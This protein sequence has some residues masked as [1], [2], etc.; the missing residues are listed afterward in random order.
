MENEERLRLLA[1]YRAGA[2]AVREAVASL[3][4]TDLDRHAGQE[5]TAREVIHHIADAELIEA[6]RLRRI[7]AE[8]G[9]HLAW[10]DEAEYARRLHYDR[11]IEAALMLFESLV[12]ANAELLQ[13]LDPG[14]WQRTGWHSID[15]TYSL[16]DWLG[17]MA[18]HA[19]DHVAQMLR[20]A[21][22]DV[23]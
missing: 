22:H 19:H 8:D 5:W 13:A 16:D 21:G 2:G 17:K 18:H 9:A 4:M 10:A 14:Q 6:E 12:T 11:P 1:L 15:G 7:L 20:A 3:S 23:I